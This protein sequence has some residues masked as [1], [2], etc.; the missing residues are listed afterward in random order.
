MV[1]KELNPA[2]LETIAKDIQWVRDRWLRIPNVADCAFDGGMDDM[3]AIAYVAYEHLDHFFKNEQQTGYRKFAL[4]FGNILVHQL[5]FEWAWGIENKSR[6]LLHHKSRSELIDV[7]RLARIET[8]K[9]HLRC[10]DFSSLY[11]RIEGSLKSGMAF[12]LD[13]NAVISPQTAPPFD[14]FPPPQSNH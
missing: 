1:M 9:A 5:A 11:S 8:E 3:N 14:T 12:P 4:V 6:L 13:Q 7:I 10:P 2:D